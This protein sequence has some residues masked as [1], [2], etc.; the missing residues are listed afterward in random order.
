MHYPQKKLFYMSKD[1]ALHVPC[2]SLCSIGSVLAMQFG[3][4]S[5]IHE[6]IKTHKLFLEILPRDDIIK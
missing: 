6:I 1:V 2:V 3:G 4:E 5:R